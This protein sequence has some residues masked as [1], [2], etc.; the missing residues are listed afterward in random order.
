MVHQ[1][2][3]D[4]L[5]I[6]GPRDH[7]AHRGTGGLKENRDLEEI[8]ALLAP[9][10]IQEN[11]GQEEGVE[12]RGRR[13]KLG[14]QVWVGPEVVQENRGQKDP[15]VHQAQG[16]KGVVLDY[17]AKRVL[18]VCLALLGHVARWGEKARL[19]QEEYRACVDQSVLR[20]Q[21]D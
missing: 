13:V 9:M 1:A 2:P 15:W 3:K 18:L 5:E 14:L 17:K 4:Q 20:G 16:A 11:G 19:A 21:L 7:P 8:E 12:N 6:E 10:V